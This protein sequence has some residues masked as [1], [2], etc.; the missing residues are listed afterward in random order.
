[1]WTQL[2]RSQR[3]SNG[4][5]QTTP[6]EQIGTCLELHV[7]LIAKWDEVLLSLTAKGNFFSPRIISAEEVK[8]SSVLKI[9]K[10]DLIT[11]TLANSQYV[12]EEDG[13]KTTH[14][15][16]QTLQRQVI[17]RFIRGKPTIKPQVSLAQCTFSTSQTAVLPASR[18]Y[19]I[20]F[21]APGT[22][23]YR[24]GA[25]TH[26]GACVFGRPQLCTYLH[27]LD[28]N[29]CVV[30]NHTVVS[31]PWGCER[32]CEPFCSNPEGEVGLGFLITKEESDTI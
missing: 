23:L 4:T 11:A 21:P 19:R 6:L 24:A 13:T 2:H 17:Q 8:P 28:C 20:L 30:K 32:Q 22:H 7:S 14:F 1:M 25:N 18:G 12:I 15:D 27:S 10:N 3:K 29:I 5:F 9:T 26:E 16:F 31:K